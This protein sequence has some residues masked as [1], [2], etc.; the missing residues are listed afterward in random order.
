MNTAAVAAAGSRTQQ[1]LLR[2]LLGFSYRHGRI[3]PLDGVSRATTP[4]AAVCS[5]L[6]L[7]LV[8]SVAVAEWP[9]PDR[10]LRRAAPGNPAAA[11]GVT[12]ALAGPPATLGSPVAIFL[13]PLGSSFRSAPGKIYRVSQTDIRIPRPETRVA[14]PGIVSRDGIGV[15]VWSSDPDDPTRRRPRPAPWRHE[16]RWDRPGLGRRHG[17]LPGSRSARRDH[18]VHGRRVPGGVW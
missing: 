3:A 16:G 8:P 5:A 11:A 7:G 9:S 15:N 4:A 6:P 2:G 10:R 12:S 14:D 1:A 18:P 17:G 13:T